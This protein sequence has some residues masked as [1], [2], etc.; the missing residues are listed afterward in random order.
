M[1]KKAKAGEQDKR[2]MEDVDEIF[3]QHPE[4][5]R[6]RLEESGFEFEEEAD[7]DVIEA[8]LTRQERL[9]SFFEG[10]GGNRRSLNSF[11]RREGI[12]RDKLSAHE[13]VFQAGKSKAQ[14]TDPLRPE[15]T[16]WQYRHPG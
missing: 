11:S 2:L 9:V 1:S 10:T 3:R 6:A 5:Y 15:K 16:P 7:I 13:E 12:R 4:Y 8:E 14:G